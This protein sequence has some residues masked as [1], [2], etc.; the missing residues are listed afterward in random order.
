MKEISTLSKFKCQYHLLM[1]DLIQYILNYN[2]L[3]FSLE[4]MLMKSILDYLLIILFPVNEIIYQELEI[5]LN[6]LNHY[7]LK[8]KFLDIINLLVL[9]IYETISMKDILLVKQ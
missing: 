2:I 6:Q 7:I 5:P 9:P 4:L 1:Y 8:L 3:Y